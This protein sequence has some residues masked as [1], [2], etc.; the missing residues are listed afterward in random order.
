MVEKVFLSPAKY[1]QGKGIL[2]TC[3]KYVLNSLGSRMLVIGGKRSFE[4]AG[5]TF[6]DTVKAAGGS[7]EYLPFKGQSSWAEIS[8]IAKT[9]EEGNYDAIVAVG[10]GKAGDTARG[11]A[12]KLKIRLGVVPSIASTDAPVASLYAI[13]S[14]K[15]E[16]QAYGFAR[17]PDLILVDTEV[18]C[19]APARYLAFGMADALATWVEA[20]ACAQSNQITTGGGRA[21]LAGLAI[22]EKCEEIIFTYGVQ[23]YEANKAQ[24]ITPALDYVVEANTLLSGIGYE[25]G[26]L[27]AAHSIH[28]GLTVLSGDIE[29]LSH[30][31]LV[32]YGTLTQLFLENQVP[33]ILDKYIRFYRK[34]NLP[35]TLADLKLGEASYEELLK[36]GEAATSEGE[37]IHRM[38]FEVTA[39]DVA[40]AMLAADAYVRAYFL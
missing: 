32:A 15:D 24:V 2:K 30:G 18:I 36:V 37:T 22:A 26:G 4:S 13:Y 34:L 12:D 40:D 8:R 33:E 27:A 25:S 21:T 5:K 39:A 1:V 29:Q 28:N 16:V 31:E 17:N 3:G 19:K 35:T 7:A 9:A 6:C 23:A 20:K 38:P 10:G 11:V 14:E